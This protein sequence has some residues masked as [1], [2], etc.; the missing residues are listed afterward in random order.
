MKRLF[1][2]LSIALILVSCILIRPLTTHAQDLLDRPVP[3]KKF[4]NELLKNVLE[5]LS[6]E[7]SFTFSYNSKVVKKKQLVTITIPAGTLGQALTDI[8]GDGYSYVMM[9]NYVIIRKNGD[10][11]PAVKAKVA[12]KA[13]RAEVRREAKPARVEV[14]A[15][16][17]IMEKKDII[18]EEKR[19]IKKTVKAVKR[20]V[21]PVRD[22][23]NIKEAKMT[24]RSIIDDIVKE[25]IVSDKEGVTSFALDGGQ[26]I[27]NGQSTADSLR[28]KFAARYIKPEGM[29]Y[30]YGP[31]NVRGRGVFMTKQDLY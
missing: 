23:I 20:R 4:S 5:E 29:G 2:R 27:V 30:Y 21:D 11:I 6:R 26:F 17:E 28:T 13:E 14:K 1:T 16:R 8:L 25:N 10:D 31:V 7:G 9:D 24:M 3:D 12:V 19:E 15:K 18:K 22:S